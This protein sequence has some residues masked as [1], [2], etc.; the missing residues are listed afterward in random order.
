[1][2][3]KPQN[4]AA[5]VLTFSKYEADAPQVLKK[6]NWDNLE[7][8]RQI[9]INLQKWSYHRIVNLFHVVRSTTVMT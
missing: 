2:L 4:R 8:R 3:Q 5:R 6:L 9:L 7:T 1:M